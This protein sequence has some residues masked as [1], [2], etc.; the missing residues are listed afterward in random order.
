MGQ[1]NIVIVDG[2]ADRRAAVYQALARVSSALPLAHIDELGHTLPD[3][4][5]FFIPDEPGALEALNAEMARRGAFRPVIVYSEDWQ[6][7]RAIDV[8][9]A[10]AIHYLPWPSLPGAMLTAMQECSEHAER[11]C[12]LLATML[13]SRARLERL[14][15]RELE[16]LER[17]HRG[18]TNKEA[19]KDLGISPRTVEIHCS[20]ILNKLGVRSKVDAMKIIV[21][22]KTAEMIGVLS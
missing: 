9:H 6:M 12:A 21:E 15:P 10:G 13:T 18:L 14:T 8:I 1:T 11:H 17:M 4:C 2:D 19:A 3:G 7:R 5:W 22:A 16:V 20:N